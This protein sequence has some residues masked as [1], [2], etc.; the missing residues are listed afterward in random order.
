V[1]GSPTPVTTLKDQ[2]GEDED[3]SDWLRDRR[4]K[5]LKQAQIEYS[6]LQHWGTLT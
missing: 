1:T 4:E 6:W 2:L 5:W 3:N